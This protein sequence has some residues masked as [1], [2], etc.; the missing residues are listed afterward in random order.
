MS[1]PDSIA[2]TSEAWLDHRLQYVR[3]YLRDL[4]HGLPSSSI[5][6][7]WNLRALQDESRRAGH[8]D[9]AELCQLMESR[10]IA[11]QAG[12][13]EDPEQLVAEIGGMCEHLRER[14]ANTARGRTTAEV[15]TM[16]EVGTT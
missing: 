7:L 16:S 5:V 9:F 14:A 3:K 8:R 10:I 1:V 15:K 13:Y 11:L 2:W 6:T 4:R 12:R